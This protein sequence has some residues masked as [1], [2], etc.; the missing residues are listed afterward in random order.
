[1]NDSK[2]VRLGLLQATPEYLQLDANLKKFERFANEAKRSGVDLF[3]T[4]EGFLDGIC[5]Q[6]DKRDSAVTLKYRQD[7]ETS[8]YLSRVREIAKATGMHI[9]FG[10]TS[11]AADHAANSAMFID[12]NGETIGIYDKTHLRLEDRRFVRGEGFKVFPSKFGSIGLLICKDRNY[13]ESSKVL[14]L[15]GAELIVVCSYG[16]W[17]ELNEWQMR[18]RARENEVHLAFAHPRTS[19]VCDAVGELVAKL[20]TNVESVLV[21]DVDLSQRPTEKLRRRRPEIYGKIAER[22]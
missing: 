4:C 16:G 2:P 19:V 15:M 10:F 13:P 11:K 14:K 5:A 12:G 1:M 7:P 6:E 18:I 9:I 22:R 20:T 8:P 3:I 21:C 17:S